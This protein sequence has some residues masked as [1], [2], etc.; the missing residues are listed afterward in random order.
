MI[1][2]VSLRY[3]ATDSDG[4][5]GLDGFS[6][7]GCQEGAGRGF[8]GFW[9]HATLRF[10]KVV[11]TRATRHSLTTYEVNYLRQ[12]RAQCLEQVSSTF[13]RMDRLVF[14]PALRRLVWC[15]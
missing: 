10:K 2:D 14:M 11:P 5:I 6:L 4:D 13:R 7:R 3:G 9:K 12:R 15:L 8:S 1:G